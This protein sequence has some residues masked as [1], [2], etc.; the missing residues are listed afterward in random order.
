[1]AP[2]ITVLC[3]VSG[4]G[5]THF[6]RALA[7]HLSG[8][9]QIPVATQLADPFGTQPPIPENALREKTACLYLDT[10]RDCFDILTQ[11][12]EG[13]DLQERLEE[14]EEISLTAAELTDLCYVLNREYDRASITEL[15]RA[16]GAP[17]LWRYFRLHYRHAAYGPGQMSLGELAA[18]V[19]LT[20]VSKAKRG[21]ILLLDEPENFLSPKARTHLIDVITAHAI[22]KHLSVVIASHSAEFVTRLPAA[23]LRVMERA[24]N[25]VTVSAAAYDSTAVRALGLSPRPRVLALVEDEVAEEMLQLILAMRAPELLGQ[26]QAALVAG[27][28]NV[29]IGARAL[30]S[31]HPRKHNALDETYETARRELLVKGAQVL[32]GRNT[33]VRVIGVLDGDSRN[34]Y[35]GDHVAYLPGAVPP[36]KLLVTALRDALTL[37]AEI[38]RI[39]DHTLASAVD[40][41]EGLDHH[42]QPREIAK[43]IGLPVTQVMATAVQLMMQSAVHAAE[44]DELIS[45][46]T[47]LLI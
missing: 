31:V 6:L 47:Q 41:A 34:K 42:D 4:V 3:G 8:D 28:G 13:L 16:D 32:W 46:L 18:S 17:G 27:D 25:S 45:C 33:G 38:L 22:K 24:G 1:M 9:D 37:G 10:A 12:T 26:I 19:I 7:A 14:A 36:E 2:G 11:T 30:G 39:P 29:D 21:Q 44:A 43:A 35:T 15:G 23:S 5:K 40:S 20:T